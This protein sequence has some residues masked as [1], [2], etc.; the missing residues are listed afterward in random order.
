MKQIFVVVLLVS[1]CGVG[2][3]VIH[4]H[5]LPSCHQEEFSFCL[6]AGEVVKVESILHGSF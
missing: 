3:P 1:L 6:K 4:F 2:L 5:V